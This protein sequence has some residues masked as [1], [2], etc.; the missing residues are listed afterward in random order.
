[1][2]KPGGRFEVVSIGSQGELVVE[3]DG[4]KPVEMYAEVSC[5]ACDWAEE[6]IVTLGRG[7]SA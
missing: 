6:R 1:M 7:T 3:E 4:G 5:C 2:V